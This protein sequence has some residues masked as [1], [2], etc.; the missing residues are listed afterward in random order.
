M[1][2]RYVIFFCV[3]TA[4]V[5]VVRAL[6]VPNAVGVLSDVKTFITPIA[7]V[8]LDTFNNPV[9]A[10]AISLTMILT[11]FAAVLYYWIAHFAP[12]YREL[13][14]VALLLDSI[15]DPPGSASALAAVDD[16]L[17][18]TRL[19]ARDWKLLKA[20][21]LV[22]PDEGSIVIEPPERFFGLARLRRAGLP[23]D[24]LKNFASDYVGLGLIFTFLGLVAGIYFAGRSMLSADLGAAR[25]A[26]IQL[27]HASTFKFLTSITGIGMS[28]LFTWAHR[29]LVRRSERQVDEVAA[30]VEDRL[31]PFQLRVSSSGERSDR[32]AKSVARSR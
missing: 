6:T 26:L 25:L 8:Y 19:L 18:S 3:L 7:A 21:F 13:K 32:L 9:T 24:A 16:V 30:L 14:R 4:L 23:I 28:L 20:R 15:T 12:A 2:R 11:G 22:G 5:L 29:V 17:S 1:L 10:V 27:L 31:Q